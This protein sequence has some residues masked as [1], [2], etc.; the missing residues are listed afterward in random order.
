[1]RT[2]NGEDLE[3]FAL[4]AAD[5]TRGIDSLAVGGHRIGISKSGQT[6]LSRW[7]FVDRTERDP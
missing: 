5:P 1:M 3:L 6:S 4:N 7:K 2:V